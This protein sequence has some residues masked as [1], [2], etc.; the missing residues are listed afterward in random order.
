[1]DNHE[2]QLAKLQ[3]TFF[4]I[5]YLSALK[6]ASPRPMQ[7]PDSTKAL[8]AACAEYKKLLCGAKETINASTLLYSF[9]KTLP[10][11]KAQWAIKPRPHKIKLA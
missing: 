6:N 1:M 8:K 4:C 7:P 3:K 5:G 9:A 11:T 2:K 10:I